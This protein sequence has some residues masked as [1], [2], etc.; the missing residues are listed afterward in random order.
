M[1]L[2]AWISM[3]HREPLIGGTFFISLLMPMMHLCVPSE[4]GSQ[5]A[6]GRARIFT[7]CSCKTAKQYTLVILK[8]VVVNQLQS[9]KM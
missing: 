3:I 2:T 4:S 5:S 1:S 9:R 7:F 8:N 6:T